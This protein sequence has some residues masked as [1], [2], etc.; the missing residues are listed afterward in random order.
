MSLNGT[1]RIR[2]ER[3]IL[4]AQGDGGGGRDRVKRVDLRYASWESNRQDW[5]RAGDGGWGERRGESRGAG[6]TPRKAAVLP[7][8]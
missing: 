1:R 2:E 3:I 5:K 6:A 4:V 8:P 7:F